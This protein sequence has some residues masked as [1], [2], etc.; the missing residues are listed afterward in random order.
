MDLRGFLIRV[1]TMDYFPHV[2]YQRVPN[3]QPGDKVLP[4]D[5]LDFRMLH[6]AAAYLNFS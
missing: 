2:D 5:C 4:K 3:H 1:V 6:T